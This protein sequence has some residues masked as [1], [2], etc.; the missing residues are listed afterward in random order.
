MATM[1]REPEAFGEHVVKIVIRDHPGCS[2]ELSGPL[3]MMLD[4]R[5]LGLENL[6]RMVQFDPLHGVE[7]VAKYFDRL[8]EGDSLSQV[9]LPFA[10]AQ[11]RIM[12]RIQPRAIFDHLD[13]EQVVH[14]PFVNDTVIVYVLDLPRMTVSLTTEQIIRWGIDVEEVDVLARR[15]LR[16]YT[17]SL[18]VR[19]VESSDGGTAGIIAMQDGYDAS[20]LLQRGLFKSLAPVLG[21][22]F[23]VGTP[24]RDMFLAMS[25]GPEVFIDRMHRRITSDFR[26]LPYPI[27]NDLF[28][29][30]LDGVAGTGQSQAA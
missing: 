17:S 7:I 25:C 28:L 3:D 9:S 16:M 2:I 4:G 30:T 20:R 13:R 19:Y 21:G 23:F 22:N 1:P 15:N 24:S 11:G 27:T 8:L 10:V 18:E 6:Y 12:P 26:R 5:H 29:V 14:L